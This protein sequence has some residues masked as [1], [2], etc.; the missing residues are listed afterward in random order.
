MKNERLLNAMGDVNYELIENALNNKPKGKTRVRLRWV[1]TAACMVLILSI[2][3][4]A[5][6]NV[7]SVRKLELIGESGYSIT[8]EI[9]KIPKNSLK[10][11]VV[12]ASDIVIEQYRNYDPYS[13][14]FPGVYEREFNFAED[15]VKYVG[16]KNLVIPFFPYQNAATEVIAECT[17]D[18]K[19]A[20]VR[21]ETVNLS[22]AV[23]VQVMSQIITTA[24][25]NDVFDEWNV[26]PEDLEYTW[27]DFLTPDSYTCQVV[28]STPLESGYQ[29]ISGYLVNDDIIYR[30]HLAFQDDNRQEAED[31][32]HTW[33]EW[34]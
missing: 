33:A 8:A 32:L 25:K 13:S 5:V 18:G 31:I 10:G 27:T 4:Y 34:F 2:T 9:K 29:T 17:E 3:A 19:I 30:I 20:S 28:E 22:E 1:A 7:F 24:Y 15:A 12:E 16:L 14:K 6:T 23:R 26:Y 21:V 11:Q